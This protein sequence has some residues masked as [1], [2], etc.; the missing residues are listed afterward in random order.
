M[1]EEK[2]EIKPESLGK[3]V[4]LLGGMSSEREVSAKSH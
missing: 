2:K 1:Q 3:V 4:L